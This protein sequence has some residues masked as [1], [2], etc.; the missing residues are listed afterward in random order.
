MKCAAEWS[1][2]YTSLVGDDRLRA[3][4]TSFSLLWGIE[5]YQML[6]KVADSSET[7]C[8]EFAA[9]Y[10][11]RFR[12]GTNKLSRN[13]GYLIQFPSARLLHLLVNNLATSPTGPISTTR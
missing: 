5:K 6:V 2:L 1:A 12:K 3:L 4:L 8:L 11:C 10:S 13:Q 7:L 9:Q